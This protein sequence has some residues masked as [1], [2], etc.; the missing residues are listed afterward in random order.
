MT[1]LCFLQTRLSERD[2]MRPE[3]RVGICRG[4][5]I[6]R[7]RSAALDH[8]LDQASGITVVVGRKV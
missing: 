1:A 4:M 8:V 3:R 6:I 7:I 2:I 5:R